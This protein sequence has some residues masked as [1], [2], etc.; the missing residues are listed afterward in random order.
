MKF[1][2]LLMSLCA[3]LIVAQCYTADAGRTIYIKNNSKASV[4]GGLY[5]T[6]AAGK[7]LNN[8]GQFSQKMGMVE[9]P[10]RGCRVITFQNAQ[11]KQ[12]RLLFAKEDMTVRGVS[13]KEV[14]ENKV[15]KNQDENKYVAFLKLTKKDKDHYV[16]S[17]NTKA[18]S[19]LR[20]KESSAFSCNTPIYHAGDLMAP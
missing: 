16:I 17:D 14:I 13:A 7:V 2:N 4:W 11:N 5:P 15:T 1:T 19:G 8:P 6:S 12:L 3:L 10:S 9:L 18:S 20:I